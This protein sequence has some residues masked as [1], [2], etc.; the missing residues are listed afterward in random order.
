[1]FLLPALQSQTMKLKAGVNI[2]L[3]EVLRVLKKG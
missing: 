3:S 2:N 1:M